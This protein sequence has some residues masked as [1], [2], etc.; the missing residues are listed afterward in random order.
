MKDPSPELKDPHPNLQ[1]CLGLKAGPNTATKK[2]GAVP[3]SPCT[4]RGTYSSLLYK[5][6]SV[7]EMYSSGR[8]RKKANIC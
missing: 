8:E 4:Q 2:T 7:T 5:G 1:L 3:S 6:F